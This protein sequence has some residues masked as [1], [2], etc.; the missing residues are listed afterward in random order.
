[1]ASSEVE[2]R[3]VQITGKGT[4]VVSLPKWWIKNLKIKRSDLIEIKPL[5][6]SSLIISLHKKRSTKESFLVSLDASRFENLDDLFRSLISK[7]LIGYDMFRISFKAKSSAYKTEL[8]E[9]IIKKLIGTEIVDESPDE[10]VVQCLLKNSDFSL[11][12]LTDRISIL[13]MSMHTDLMKSFKEQSSIVTYEQMEKRDDEVDRLYF[14]V[15]RQLNK[16]IRD[17]ALLET[18]GMLK[19]TDGFSYIIA[20]KSIERIADHAVSIS[21]VMS[22]LNN[23]VPSKITE[24]LL[25]MYSTS[26]ELFKDSVKTLQELEI[27]IEYSF[28]KLNEVEEL[29]DIIVN[30]IINECK[31][32]KVAV[33]LRLVVESVKRVAEYSIDIAEA[34]MNIIAQ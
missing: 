30:E 22:G 34:A 24:L 8:K 33:N 20:I 13:T 11:K 9:K 23:S 12:K 18:L 2:I 28:S 6:N 4:Y 27:A 19:M 21:K 10:I 17:P 14:F 31:N 25:K 3:K 7:Y 29:N 1:M 26:L 15:V 32:T 16:A 5:L